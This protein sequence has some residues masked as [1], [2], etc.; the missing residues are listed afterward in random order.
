MAEVERPFPL[1]AAQ[2]EQEEWIEAVQATPGVN[3]PREALQ[4]IAPFVVEP[5][6]LLGAADGAGRRRLTESALRRIGTD[7]GGMTVVTVRM[8]G[9]GGVVWENNERISS[10]WHSL[11]DPS[12]ATEE[13]RSLPQV[14]AWTR[15]AP[16][17][18][19]QA[20]A[21]LRS[22]VA[23]RAELVADVELAT[24]ALGKRVGHR[25]YNLQQDLVL[26]GQLEPGLFV[27]QQFQLAEA[28]LTDDNGQPLHP[29]E[30]WGWMAVRGNNRTK[31]RQEIFGVSSAEVLTGVPLKR[32][33]GEGETLVFDPEEWLG[34]LSET[35]NEEYATAAEWDPESSSRAIRAMKVA[36]VEAQ[37]VVGSTAPH[38]LYRIAQ[39][40]NRRDHVHPPLEF[41]QNDRGRALARSVLGAYVAEG[42]L[43]ERTAEVLSGSAPVTDLPGAANNGSVSE[44]RDL[45]SMLLLRELFPAERAKRFVIRR[46]LS[47][48][49]PSQLTAT[50]VNL[51]ARAWSA[52][53]SESYPKAWNPRVGEVF[54]ASEVRDGVK[55]SDRPLRELLEA[56]DKDGAAFEEIVSYRAAHWLAAF[57]IIEA[58]RGSLA[59]Q[60]A[61]DEDEGKEATRV[62]RTVRNALN[63]LRNNNRQQAVAVLRELARAMDQ[64]DRKPRRVS[65]SGEALVDPMNRT[66]FNREFPKAT[67]TRST[68]AKAPGTQGS[69]SP[70]PSPSPS[71][72]GGA[73]PV[74]TESSAADQETASSDASTPPPGLAD[75][76]SLEQ[77]AKELVE[78]VGKLLDESR[79]TK[80]LLDRMADRAHQEVAPVAFSR[81]Q[82]DSIARDV[83]RTLRILRE[84]PEMVEALAEPGD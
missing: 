12:E 67:G 54:Q 83:P 71:Q 25:P 65:Q 69:P 10:A 9:V 49:P 16:D 70:S 29:A 43:D 11:A 81:G 40:S 22:S 46:V 72:S 61:G 36:V 38:R 45:R 13:R 14:H 60:K 41:T 50:E 2:Q 8:H 63:A 39:M 56:A 80:E 23:S 26:N 34:K 18:R 79:L 55:P 6:R 59:G 30:Y 73:V 28:P 19:E 84:L 4:N 68:K 64:G 57:G 33:G 31:E 44:L 48:S 58:D 15:S 77:L 20:F 35:L 21:A 32:L 5:G 42:L 24:E 74:P 53:T 47:E 76:T 75:G 1:P 66:W 51:R 7:A 82:A 3:V 78:Q 37:L 17:G 52:L 27:A 62:R